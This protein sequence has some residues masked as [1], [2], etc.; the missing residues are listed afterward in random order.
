MK[1]L[2]LDCDP[3]HDDMMAIMVAL[4][5]PE[6]TLRGI[7]TVAGNQTGEKTFANAGRVLTLCNAVEVPLARGYDAPILRPLTIAPDIHGVSGLD[8]ADLPESIVKP[9]KEHAVEFLERTLM[10]ASSPITLVPTGPLTNIAMLLRKRPEVTAH[11]DRICLMGGAVRESNV[12]PCAEFNI[13]VDP[14]AAHIV[15]ESGVPITMVGLDVT[16]RAIVTLEDIDGI[17]AQAGAVSG[18]VGPLLRFFASAYRQMFGIAGA[19]LHDALAMLAAVE[20]EVLTTRRLRVDVET[21]GTHT[22]GQTVTDLYGVTDAPPNA[23]VA[24]DLDIDRFKAV[25]LESIAAMDA[26]SMIDR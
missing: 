3:G 22:R 14:E 23:D 1:E 9:C 2:L 11:I 6:I 7:T 21:V 5:H 16:N 8:G 13:F 4:A 15:F 24:L 20:P 12:T 10:G 26:G 18:I 17:T 19:P 25:I